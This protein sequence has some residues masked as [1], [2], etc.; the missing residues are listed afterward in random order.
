M[1][2]QIDNATRY[3]IATLSASFAAYTATDALYHNIIL[4]YRPRVINL[5]DRRTEF[6]THHT[7]WNLQ[8]YGIT[9]SMAPPYLPLDTPIIVEDDSFEGESES[10][11]EMQALV[12]HLQDNPDGTALSSRR[13]SFDL[14]N[15]SLNS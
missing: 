5:S 8:E 3:V 11:A 13:Y 10:A 9:Q 4:Q 7:Q 6:T 1:L 12:D 2:V 15:N 14:D